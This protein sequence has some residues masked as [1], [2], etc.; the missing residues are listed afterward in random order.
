MA[1]NERGELVTWFKVDDGFWSHEK[2]IGLSPEAGWLWTRAGSYCAHQLTDG[3]VKAPI[4]VLLG[5]TADTAA[6]L[7][8]AGLWDAVKGGYQFHDWDKYQPTREEVESKRE[9]WKE[10]QRAARS[11]RESRSDTQGDSERESAS[12]V[13]SRPV[14]SPSSTKKV[15]P[16]ASRGSRLDP[17][18][19]PPK[20]D[21][22]KIRSECPGIDPQSEHL[23]FVD[24]WIAQPGQKGVKVDWPATWRNWMRR[25]QRD[26]KGKAT[27]TEK[28]R[29]TV[30]L[31]TEL[32]EVES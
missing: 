12:P 16:S 14:P 15:T 9:A 2:V 10:R 29:R 23:E 1:S 5:G 8:S 11:K 30:M 3:A 18:W 17:S 21:V 28:A 6:E 22:A 27:P 31:A 25:K 7:I 4:L 26:V 24:Y 32:L 13:P 19:L 20:E